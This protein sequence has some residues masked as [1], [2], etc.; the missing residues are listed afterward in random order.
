MTEVLERLPE[1]EVV[2]SV[3]RYYTFIYRPKTPRIR[4]DEYPLIACTE[5]TRWGFRG[6]NYHWGNFRNYTWEEVQSNLHVIY[7]MELEDLRSINYQ[8]FDLNI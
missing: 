5:V 4:Y 3:G 6:I 7:P 2:P 8:K 1:V